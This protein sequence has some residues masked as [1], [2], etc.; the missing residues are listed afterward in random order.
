[1]LK[2]LVSTIDD[3]DLTQERRDDLAAMNAAGPNGHRYGAS[4]T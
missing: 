2:S 1:V 3:H 4:T